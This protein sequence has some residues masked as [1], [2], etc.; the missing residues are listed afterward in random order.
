MEG[1]KES[2]DG[3]VRCAALAAALAR[4]YQRSETGYETGG[5]RDSVDGGGLFVKATKRYYCAAGES[6]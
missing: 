5:V 6:R 2:G 1:A 4:G 3:Q